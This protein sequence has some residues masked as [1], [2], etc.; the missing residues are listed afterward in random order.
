MTPECSC[1]GKEFTRLVSARIE[2]AVIEVCERCSKFGTK[3]NVSPTYIPIKKTIKVSELGETDL[4]LVPDYGRI[5]ARVRESKG[6]TRYDLAKKINE[7]ESVIK[8]VEDEELE[9][10]EELIRKIEDFLDIR[11]REKNETVVLQRREKK[12]LPLTVGDVVEIS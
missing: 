4:E 9:P 7:K 12:K 1:C 10:D 3:V 8:R 5:I 6:L 11:L 2:G